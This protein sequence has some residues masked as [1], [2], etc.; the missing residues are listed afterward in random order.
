[1]RQQSGPSSFGARA[2]ARQVA[3]LA[4]ER[5][6]VGTAHPDNALT[7]AVR[8]YRSPG[9]ARSVRRS[10]LPPEVLL[11]IRVAAG[12]PIA[13]AQAVAAT[14]LD[15]PSVVRIA[16]LYLLVALF[17]QEADP[18]RTLGVSAGAAAELVQDHKKWLLKWLHPD[19]NP[20]QNLAGLSV[21]VLAASAELAARPVEVVVPA[22]AAPPATPAAA[23]SAVPAAAAP[24]EPARPR[25]TRQQRH[26]WL[27]LQL[28]G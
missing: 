9:L 19:R 7:L 15:Q 6:V 23:P 18:H 12:C 13:S 5:R 24:V 3:G 4:A 21:R 8:L 25:R 1:M 22:A 2:A 26:V 20:N 10:A 11:V 27:P 17:G 28:D 16:E 14:G